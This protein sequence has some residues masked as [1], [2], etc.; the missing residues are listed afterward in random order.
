M[1]NGRLRDRGR[2]QEQKTGFCLEGEGLG[3]RS[4]SKGQRGGEQREQLRI[5]FRIYAC[6]V[7]R[8]R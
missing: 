3:F 1:T 7:E 8:A 5:I 4:K 2:E 6:V